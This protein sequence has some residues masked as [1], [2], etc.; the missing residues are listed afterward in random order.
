MG[1]AF[2]HSTHS[3]HNNPPG[4]RRPGPGP[5]PEQQW[6]WLLWLAAAKKRS[7]K[8]AEPPRYSLLAAR[9]EAAPPSPSRI[10][11]PGQ[12]DWVLGDQRSA[13]PAARNIDH[14]S[15]PGSSTGGSSAW[16]GL[17][18]VGG[19]QLGPWPAGFGGR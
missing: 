14:R 19:V 5:G 4:A 10:P 12:S 6:L 9:Y 3:T 17:G 16:D 15:P 8:T 7:F 13:R 1:M 18:V 2:V 11:D